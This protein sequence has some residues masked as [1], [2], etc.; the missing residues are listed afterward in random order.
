MSEQ[1]VKQWASESIK[2][3]KAREKLQKQWADL[4][5]KVTPEALHETTEEIHRWIARHANQRVHLRDKNISLFDENQNAAKISQRVR[6]IAQKLN[7]EMQ[8]VFAS[9][10]H[11]D[12]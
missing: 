11:E 8:Q 12:S 2:T 1:D 3:K 9:I 4:E 5:K 6:T 10:A 7:A